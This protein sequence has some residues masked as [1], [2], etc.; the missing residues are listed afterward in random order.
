[1][2]QKNSAVIQILKQNVLVAKLKNWGRNHIFKYWQN[3]D[4]YPLN[5]TSNS[6]NSNNSSSHSSNS[7]SQCIFNYSRGATT[8][9]SVRSIMKIHICV[10][11]MFS[12]VF[13]VIFTSARQAAAQQRQAIH[14]RLDTLRETR[15]AAGNTLVTHTHIGFRLHIGAPLQQHNCRFRVSIHTCTMKSCLSTLNI[16]QRD[17]H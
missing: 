10:F 15:Q 9:N 2:S 13:G 16:I 5:C 11:D 6:S 17:T 1:M 4:I 8:A 14:C 12:R 7:S 3:S